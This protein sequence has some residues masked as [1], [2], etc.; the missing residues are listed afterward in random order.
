MENHSSISPKSESINQQM[1]ELTIR[2]YLIILRL[3][4]K[5]LI[6]FTIF[7]M[8]F[9]FYKIITVPP[10]YTATATVAIREKPGAGMIMDLTG[11]RDRN[12][13]SN[14]IQLI[15]SRSVAKATV[16]ELWPL[17]KNNLALFGSYPF[18]PRGRRARTFIKE[19]F[20]LGL[21]DPKSE[22]PIQYIDDYSNDIG[23][24]FAGGV[25]N[26]LN[27]NHRTGTDI[28]DISYTSVWPHESKLLVNTLVDIY[29]KFELRLS[30]EYAENSVEF[31]QSLLLNQDQK[32]R[33]AEK[34]FTFFK[35]KE[36]MYD[37][38]GIA[39][40]ITKQVTA[41]E[42]EVYNALAEIN[43]RK[44]KI[45][46]F[47]S[48]LSQDEKILAD[49]LLNNINIQMLSLRSEIGKLESQLIQ[50]IA[51]YG[52]NHGAVKGLQ[53]KLEGLKEQLNL[54][55]KDLTEMGI[56]V[57]D[58]LQARQDIVM[59]LIRLD[60]EITSFELKKKESQN[61]LNIYL[62]K[63]DV[64]P[65]KQLDFSRLQRNA[66]VLNQNYN[67]IRKKLEEAKI[68]VASQ[69]GK[70]QI[71]DYARLPGVSGQ[72]HNRT[73]IIGLIFGLG[74]GIGL[75]FGIELLD[76]TVKSV[77]DVARNNLVVLGVIPSIGDPEKRKKGIFFR[78]NIFLSASGSRGLRRR[79]MTREDPKSPVSEAYRSLR[80]SLLYSSSNKEPK[81]ILISSAG[82][83]EG[84]TTTVANL[85]I[86]Y[87][88]LG[89][90]TLLVD[91]DLR[92]PVV[93]KV[94]ELN[95]EPGITTYLSSATD[96]YTSLIQ[97]CE[98]DNLG[99]ITAGIIPPNPSELLG[100]ERMTKLVKELENDWDIVLFDSPPLVAV[101]DATMISKEIDQIIMVV[102]VGQT[103]KK[104]FAHTLTNLR[105]VG[106]PLGGI[107]MNAVTHK[108][109]YGSYYYYY[110]YQ[111]YHYY[112]SDKE[113]I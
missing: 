104:A 3:H 65:Q 30:G 56:T 47:K 19:L 105:N 87:A 112:G 61:L 75:A 102:K 57:Q 21:Y 70:V 9:A 62:D 52:E 6:S 54:K 36:R 69:V 88:N 34:K 48:K 25:I 33:D 51:Q 26:R 94:F 4:Y 100:S 17:K 66:V 22:A 72:N 92:R 37:L 7:G 107:I 20:T 55:V 67:L 77:D 40:D 28:I 108:S 85:A 15:K 24:R 64:L 60:T 83:G 80:T 2:D 18:Y 86:T 90:K 71:I 95:R 44:G 5:K 29:K 31:L 16:K 106:A 96:N 53:S 89:K 73:L 1:T 46:L 8:A 27:I 109:S 98:I 97:D 59:E 103:D 82:P 39:G 11:N 113:S 91:T 111:Y 74:A 76:N 79:L 58:P 101:T 50:N 38:D 81:S 43:I 49:R 10:S 84:K 41:I 12:R 110:Y 99:I 13:M 35:N 63:L 23:E 93:H 14:E 78:K 45:N 42:S 32:L 68:N